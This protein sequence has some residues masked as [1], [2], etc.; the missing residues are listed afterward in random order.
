MNISRPQSSQLMP[1]H[2]ECVFSGKIFDTYQ[3]NQTMYDGSIATFEKVKRTDTVVVFA[4][5]DN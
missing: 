5:L 3:R 2:A 1:E 4:I